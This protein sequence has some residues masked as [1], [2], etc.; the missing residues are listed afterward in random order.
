M[1]AHLEQPEPMDSAG[2]QNSDSLRTESFDKDIAP[3]FSAQLDQ[4]RDSSGLD[5]LLT[6]TSIDTSSSTNSVTGNSLDFSPGNTSGR[7]EAA[8]GQLNIPPLR[9]NQLSIQI[10]EGKPSALPWNAGFENQSDTQKDGYRSHIEIPKGLY[11]NMGYKIDFDFNPQRRPQSTNSP[12]QDRTRVD[13]QPERVVEKPTSSGQPTWDEVVRDRTRPTDRPVE[14]VIGQDTSSDPLVFS[15]NDALSLMSKRALGHELWQRSKYKQYLD[16]GKLADAASVS[17]VL[18]S[19]GYD[20]A[21]SSNTGNL[22]KKLVANGW[23]M[24][25]VSQAKPGDVIFGGKVGTR[26]QTD[27]RNA[28]IGI[29]GE[30]GSVF[31]NNDGKWSQ[32][33]RDAVFNREQYG[34]QVW[35]LRPPLDPP[36][37]GNRN[38]SDDFRSQFDR[39]I[40]NNGT[41][42]N[43]NRSDRPTDYRPSREGYQ[44]DS[45]DNPE[46][47]Y[48]KNYWKQYWHDYWR[49]YYGSQN[50]RENPRDGSGY[51]QRRDG[52]DGRTEPTSIEKS[53]RIW[54][55]S[56]RFLGQRVWENSQYRSHCDN[57]RRGSTPSVTEVL[58]ASGFDYANAGHVSALARQLLSRGW[59]PVALNDLRPGDVLYGGRNDRWQEGGGNA[60]TAIVGEAGVIY[61]NDRNTGV[62]TKAH[63]GDAFPQHEFGRRIW[64]L[65]PPEKTIEIPI[66]PERN[67]NGSDGNLAEIARAS[68]GRQ[69]WRFI[70]GTPARLGCAAS[71]SAVLSAGGYDYARHAGVGGLESQLTR[72]GWQKMHVSQAQPGDVVIGARTRYYRNGGGGSHIGVVGENGRVYHNSSGRAKWIET[73]LS[74]YYNSG[75]F[76]AG[77]WILRPPGQRHA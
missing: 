17:L 11:A 76:R 2:N 68:V 36:S 15:G 49:D 69:L 63:V 31:H 60:H 6:N 77:V 1:T 25:G 30:N 53:R 22:V 7:L 3:V 39:D 45:T 48:W 55:T 12:V 21:D 71:V 8:T 61:H 73:S 13:S 19:V 40:R 59:T 62:W 64:A 33:N 75:R 74:G 54:D 28:G 51:P 4:S 18:N 41:Q 50:R 57:G 9:S 38:S 27:S 29:V 46:S 67:Y 24:V 20:Y 58:K 52:A 35:V 44:Y 47:D 10:A 72:N 66:R 65:R 26:W 37:R 42:D 32:N 16:G 34:D 23:E 70:R 14:R 43:G 56:E 5:T